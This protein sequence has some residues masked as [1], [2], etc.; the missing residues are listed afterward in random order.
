MIFFTLG[1]TAVASSD[2]NFK[3]L[4]FKTWSDTAPEIIVCDKSV[5]FKAV[6]EATKFWK[7]HGFKI[8]QPVVKENC[9]RDVLKHKIKFIKDTV[10][11]SLKDNEN[12]VTDRFFTKNKMYGA[13]IVIKKH[14]QDQKIL[15]IHEL[16][17]ALGL[18]HSDNSDN[19][20]YYKKRY[21]ASNR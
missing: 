17:H 13:N 3:D 7:Q 6:V 10:P 18:V 8:S 5:N 11:S 12:G 20:M 1:S 9:S 19:V 14:L 4:T 16:G 15:I 21:Y 2:F